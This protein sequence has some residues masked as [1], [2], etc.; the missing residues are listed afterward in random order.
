[1]PFDALVDLDWETLRTYEE[2]LT[3]IRNE[4]NG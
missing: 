1:M 3:E 2:V 4:T